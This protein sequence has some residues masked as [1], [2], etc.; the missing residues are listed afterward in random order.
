[1]LTF[2]LLGA[3]MGWAHLLGIIGLSIV[4]GVIMQTV[5]WEKTG[6]S[7]AGPVA[8]PE[9]EIKKGKEIPAEAVK[10]SRRVYLEDG[11]VEARI[12]ERDG[13][14]CGNAIE[15]PAIVEEPFHTTLVMPGQSLEVDQFGNLI[16]LVGGA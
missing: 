3:N 1:M 9:I 2:R 15:G 7:P 16:I 10:P 11:F 13:L 14:L 8:I 6:E 5:F 12:F 4:V